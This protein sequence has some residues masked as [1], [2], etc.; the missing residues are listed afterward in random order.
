MSFA[1]VQVMTGSKPMSSSRFHLT[2]K[3]QTFGFAGR[4][5]KAMRGGLQ[6]VV[7][8]RRQLKSLFGHSLVWRI[9]V[10]H[11]SARTV[12]TVRIRVTRR[13]YLR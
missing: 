5:H 4:A 8:S 6:I 10:T 11:G 13:G 7:R 12:E 9:V 1:T 2:L 3:R